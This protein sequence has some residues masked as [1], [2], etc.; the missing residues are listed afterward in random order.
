E[1]VAHII[2]IGTSLKLGRIAE[3]VATIAQA[4]YMRAHGVQFAQG[5]LFSRPMDIA[6]LHD[7]IRGQDVPPPADPA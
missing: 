5:W 7:G 3:G 1:V 6:Q 4:D 2:E